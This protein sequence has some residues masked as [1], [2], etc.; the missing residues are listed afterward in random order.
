MSM[1]HCNKDQCS[2]AHC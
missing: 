2:E 1:H